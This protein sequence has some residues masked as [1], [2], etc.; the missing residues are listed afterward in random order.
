MER[1]MALAQESAAAGSRLGQYQLGQL[2]DKSKYNYWPAD[3]AV[4]VRNYTL[5]AAQHLAPAQFSLGYLHEFG[6][7]ALPIDH[8]EAIRL[9]LAAAAQGHPYAYFRLARCYESGRGLPAD[10]SNAIDMYMKAQ[11]A[12]YDAELV[13]AHL[14]RLGA[15]PPSNMS[16]VLNAARRAMRCTAFWL[17]APFSFL[18]VRWPLSRRRTR[19]C[20]TLVWVLIAHTFLELYVDRSSIQ[21]FFLRLALP[22]LAVADALVYPH[23]IAA[24]SLLVR[25]LG[26]L[27]HPAQRQIKA[28]CVVLASVI[29]ISY[30]PYFGH[31]FVNAAI[32]R[33]ISQV[34]A[35]LVTHKALRML[36]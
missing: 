1:S 35:G 21:E 8:A 17:W 6:C 22:L 4:A 23:I 11:A 24:P 15:A 13:H 19:A 9:Y 3:I 29:I 7:P 31:Y 34:V 14:V 32:S 12:G 18:A 26:C 5:A 25:L 36:Q 16:V 33:L 30:H 27:L 20:A 2:H 28:V 10:R